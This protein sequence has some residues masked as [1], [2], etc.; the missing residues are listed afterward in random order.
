M[1]KG[2]RFFEFKFDDGSAKKAFDMTD[3]K[4]YF[5]TKDVD[6]LK[7]GKV[8]CVIKNKYTGSIREEEGEVVRVPY[9]KTATAED[10]KK[11]GKNMIYV[12]HRH[13]DEFVCFKQVKR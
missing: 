7:L 4:K 6:K 11:H 9:K 10:R 13:E 8:T 12:L 3:D 5:C 2:K 1:D